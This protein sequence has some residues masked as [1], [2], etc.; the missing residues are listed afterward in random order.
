M[1]AQRWIL[2]M[3]SRW[4]CSSFCIVMN[5]P[6]ISPTATRRDLRQPRAAAGPMVVFPP[7]SALVALLMAG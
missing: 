2:G 6:C 7:L 4:V 1:R 3:V 5:Q